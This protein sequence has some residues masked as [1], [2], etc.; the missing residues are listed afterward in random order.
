MFS[1]VKLSI[2]QFIFLSLILWKGGK[3]DFMSFYPNSADTDP[4]NIWYVFKPMKIGLKPSQKR[5]SN[6][7]DIHMFK[8]FV[9]YFKTC[10][11][12]VIVL[13]F[14][15]TLFYTDMLL[16]LFFSMCSLVWNVW[17]VKS[18]L[19]GSQRKLQSALI[20]MIN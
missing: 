11:E 6:L 1:Y 19:I 16:L 9:Q 15:Y 12:Q 5:K 13:D 17:N 3:N 10:W 20:Y 7:Q 18:C 4:G 8:S 14:L 2:Q